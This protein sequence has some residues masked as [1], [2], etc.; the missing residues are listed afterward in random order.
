MPYLNEAFPVKIPVPENLRKFYP[1]FI[2][3]GKYSLE[4]DLIDPE[5]DLILLG[6]IGSVDRTYLNGVLI[7]REGYAEKEFSVSAF[8]KVR[9]YS[10]PRGILKPN[11]NLIEI[12]FTSMDIK[13]GIHAGPLMIGKKENLYFTVEYWRVIREYIFLAMPVIL[14]IILVL[15]LVTMSVWRPGEGNVFLCLAF[16]AYFFRAMYFIP[17]PWPGDYLNFLKIQWLGQYVA[18]F[19][20]IVYFMRTFGIHSKSFDWTMH[21]FLIMGVVALGLSGT[22]E[23]EYTIEMYQHILVNIIVAL[24][25]FAKFW[26]KNPDRISNWKHYTGASII[27]II[28]N[29]FDI[30]MRMYKINTPWLYHY[31]SVI[32]TINFLG[33]Y[34]FHIYIWKEESKL[35]LE[36]KLNRQK[37]EIANELHDIMGSELSQIVVL[38][39]GDIPASKN[40]LKNL[41][42]TSLE[43]VRDFSRVL[44]GE[45]K[46]LPLNELIDFFEKRLKN[47]HR[48]DIEIRKDPKTKSLLSED[49]ILLQL[50]RILSEWISNILKHSKPTKIIIGTYY[51]RKSNKVYVY[52]INSPGKFKWNGKAEKGGLLSIRNRVSIIGGKVFCLARNGESIFF[53]SLKIK[54]KSKI[55]QKI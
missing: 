46:P 4:F 40:T 16:I 2:G 44:K 24:L 22:Y 5:S 41:A 25:I 8:N 1:H 54:H 7:G 52:I 39:E 13:S 38:S 53:I 32:N 3:E 17:F 21:A 23:E 51:Q 20:S 34:M 45:D 47:L 48:F 36:T 33:F 31:M 6:S 27:V 42:K 15:F 43:K 30:F 12:Y 29:T 19:V 26:I 18:Q 35:E 55:S 11:N 50:E 49:L 28:L 37:L 14:I 9:E 10:I